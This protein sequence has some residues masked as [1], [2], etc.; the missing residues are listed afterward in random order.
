M[1]KAKTV[2]SLEYSTGK[3]ANA[4][5]NVNVLRS[6]MRKAQSDKIEAIIAYDDTLI[7][8]PLD[9]IGKDGECHK[10]SALSDLFETPALFKS[11]SSENPSFGYRFALEDFLATEKPSLKWI[12]EVTKG[13]GKKAKRVQETRVATAREMRGA[14][15]DGWGKADGDLNR[16]NAQ[17]IR[18]AWTSFLAKRYK[19][20]IADVYEAYVTDGR[21]LT[22]KMEEWA[23]KQVTTHTRTA[24]HDTIVKLIGSETHS[25]DSEYFRQVVQPS[26]PAEVLAQHEAKQIRVSAVGQI[27]FALNSQAGRETYT[28]SFRSKVEK[29]CVT[30]YNNIKKAKECKDSKKSS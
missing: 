30:L 26:C 20:F 23:T 22:K 4:V 29:Y 21:K 13:T 12:H 19:T 17:A 6:K 27:M 16:E 5:T 8:N 10:L 3:G 1:P 14:I 7:T 24:N 15:E 9:V 18:G 2:V 25:P 28:S 11:S